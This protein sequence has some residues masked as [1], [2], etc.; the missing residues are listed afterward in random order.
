MSASKN[1]SPKITNRQALRDYTINDK[2]ETGI[3]LTGSEVK[4]IRGSQASFKGAY[5]SISSNKLWLHGL[6]IEPYKFDSNTDLASYN[7][8][9]PRQLLVHTR[10]LERLKM[11][12]Q[13]KGESLIPLR[14]YF[15]GALIKVEI[16]IGRGKKKFDKRA[17]MKEK[18]VKREQDRYIKSLRQ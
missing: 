16:G 13:A 17:D 8:T 10:E 6:H 14:L 18:V 15:K 9:H 3:V 1:F 4:A 5:A 12:T 2:V 7:P 11:D